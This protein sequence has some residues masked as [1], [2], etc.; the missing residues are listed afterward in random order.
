MHA[1]QSAVTPEAIVPGPTQ[2][3]LRRGAPLR[4]SSE[5]PRAA[6][7]RDVDAVPCARRPATAWPFAKPERVSTATRSSHRA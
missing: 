1:R 3:D 6:L 7:G 2:P 5:A 4:I